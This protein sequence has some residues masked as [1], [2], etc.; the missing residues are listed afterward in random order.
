MAAG[1]TAQTKGFDSLPGHVNTYEIIYADGPTSHETIR[2]HR[3]TSGGDGYIRFLRSDSLEV[4]TLVARH[5][6]S[7]RWVDGTSRHAVQPDWG[8]GAPDGAPEL[9]ARQRVPERQP[10]GPITPEP[11]EGV[12][13]H[14][15]VY[16]TDEMAEVERQRA[17]FT[18]QYPNKP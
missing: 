5:V 4:L 7:V 14:F 6:L 3:M 15:D 10:P 17:R 16:A 12:D 1:A 13:E 18:E 9:T 2:S 11:E 8:S